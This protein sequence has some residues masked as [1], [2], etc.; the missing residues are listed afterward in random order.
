[1]NFNLKKFFPHLIV[2]I[3]F[4][5]GALAYFS[6]VLQ[7]KKIFQSDIAQYIGMAKE[8]NDYRQEHHKEPYWT[9]SA[10]GGMPTFQL[11]AKYPHNYIKKLDESIRFLPRPAD[12]LFL[13]FISFYILLLI[14][15]VDWKLAFLGS[16][17]FGFS[18]YLI[19]ILGVGHNAKAHA[20][21]YFPL[22]IGGIILTFRRKLIWGFLLTAIAMALE[23]NANH[24]QMTY[25][26]MLLVIVIGI[27]YLIDAYR[28]KELGHYFKT[29]G[30]LVVAVL[31]GIATNATNLMATKQYADWST[32]GKSELTINPD[33]SPKEKGAG[34]SYDYIT[35]YS[36]GISES[37]NLF[38][39]RLMGG[40]GYETLDKDSNTYK[41][42]I[43]IGVP[44]NQ[45]DAL[46]ENIPTY[47]GDQPIVAAPAYVGAV[48]IFLFVLALFLVKG[49]IKYWLVGGTLISLLLSWG[50]N[51]G[52]LT[53]FMIDYFPM[54][55]KFR[56]VSSIQVILEMCIPALGIYGLHQ[57]FSKETGQKEK[58]TALKNAVF[59]VGGNTILLFIGKGFFSFTGARDIMFS[60][61]YAQWGLTDLMEV[62]KED[63]KAMY[64]NDLLRSLILVLLTSAILFA[65][66]KEKLK[67]NFAFVGIGLL[68]VFD[69]VGIDKKY[70]SND[71]FITSRQL[72][73]P[74]QENAADLQILKDTGYYRV[75]EPSGGLAS[76]RASYYHKSIGGYHAAKPGRFQELYD[77]QIANN[78]IAIL[79]M[80]N[81][82]YIIQ[83]NENGYYASRNPYANGASW[84]VEKLKP[85]NNA[86]EEMRA[87][88]SL[89]VKTEAVVDVSKFGDL[90]KDKSFA[91]DSTAS[92]TLDSFE[93]DHLK[94]TSNNTKDGV[95]VF[96]EIYYPHGWKAT[97][98]GNEVKSFRV[99]YVLRALNVPAG[100]HTIEFKFDP[101]VVK[102]GSR[103]TL[104]SSIVLIILLAAG[105]FYSFKPAGS[106]KTE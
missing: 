14:L 99:N 93:P 95:A 8:Q 12:Y 40:A 69:L 37:L 63:R 61:Q 70:V 54:Y 66:L 1:M 67:A 72:D 52:F 34:L 105:I 10:F 33:G 50:K 53:D 62:I 68:L 3:L 24:I 77:Y 89:K 26:L 64:T 43:N 100:K 78:N 79:N 41:Y 87:M 9:N 71:D 48:V 106:K 4:I 23:I 25:Y 22:V 58:L 21:G 6:P 91:V 20:I 65:A 104:G 30:I 97:I 47:W 44:R 73:K 84:F 51:F 59:V 16:L 75:F 18:T 83:Q 29:I 7:G 86:T 57:L 11:G 17:A 92:I 13:Y 90:V 98:D 2:I 101:E 31:L 35:E 88:D 103:I 46:T 38:S 15:K 49:K 85:V 96:S 76:A 102:T 27:V 56:A 94:Y 45:A 19:I 39:A 36:Y 74:F 28:K 81:V 55:N 80:L 82:K 5:I 60:Q 42:L 32:R